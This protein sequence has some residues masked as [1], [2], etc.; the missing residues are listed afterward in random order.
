MA[1][2][3]GL[4]SEPRRAEGGVLGEGIKE[5]MFPPHHQLGVWEELQ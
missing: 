4:K 5:G 2:P 1:R 3:G